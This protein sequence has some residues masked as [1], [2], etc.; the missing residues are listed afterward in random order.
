MTPLRVF[1]KRLSALF[2]KQALEQELDDELQFHFEQE[3]EHHIA[4]GMS[5]E[6]ARCRARRRFGGVDAMKEIYR[7]TRGLPVV[8]AFVQDVRYRLRMLRAKPGFTAAAVLT[9]TLGIGANTA[10][11]SLVDAVLLRMLPVQEPQRLVSVLTVNARGEGITFSYPQF[12]YMREHTRQ[13]NIFAYTNIPLNLSSG[14]VTDAPSGELVSD[15]YFSVLGVQ[16][17]LGRM[18]EAGDEN[19]AVIGHRFW[20]SRF[21][22]DSNVVGRNINL[23]GLPFT[24]IGVA[25]PRFFGVEVGKAPDI[26]VPLIMRDRMS[27]GRPTL[28]M[29]NNFWLNLMARLRPQTSAAEAGAEA[30]VVYQQS[31]SDQIL[32]TGTDPRLGRYLRNRHVRLAPADKGVSGLRGQFR[33]P[34]LIVM[35]IVAL[36]LLIACANVASLLLARAAA[37]RK[38]IAVR[39]A[40]GAGRVRLF[41][42]M[43]TESMVLSIAGCLLGVLFGLWSAEALVHLLNQSVLDTSLDLRVLGFTIAVSI[44]YGSAVQRLACAALRTPGSQRRFEGRNLGGRAR[45]ASGT[46]ERPG[47]RAGG[48]LALARTRC[49]SV[50]SHA[51]KLEGPRSWVPWRQCASGLA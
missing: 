15:N 2:R 43:V 46:A 7:D 9:L 21:G 13:L 34:L 17:L 27:P 14:P 48:D 1:L 16:P 41:R 24:V 47:G 10:I 40:L 28:P 26:F 3:M 51:R 32:G 44:L 39:L 12:V 20:Q 38:E 19:A 42:Q 11:F 23:N 35:T 36:V 8:E 5:A 18:L 4:H 6:E 25:P 30:E 29:N 31:A 49:G 50:P 37:R 22:A 45:V 33:R